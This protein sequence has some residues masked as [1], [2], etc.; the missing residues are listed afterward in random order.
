MKVIN[1][2]VK[3]K[4]LFTY[5]LLQYVLKY[6]ILTIVIFYTI[7]FFIKINIAQI[8]VQILSKY[9]GSDAVF[10][11]TLRL[12][13]RAESKSVDWVWNKF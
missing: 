4:L 12:S 13:F 2:D 11:N 8:H 5:I 10:D 9:S 7:I 6:V 1:L 3:Y